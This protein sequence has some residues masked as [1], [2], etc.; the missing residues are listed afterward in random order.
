[1]TT[2]TRFSQEVAPCGRTTDGQRVRDNDDDG[3]V[4]DRMT[5]DCGCQS[6]RSQYH[7]GGVRLRVVDHHGRVRSDEHSSD[8]E[9]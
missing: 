4:I 9:A 6:T 5:Y 2:S 1:M 7:D 8:H 3:F